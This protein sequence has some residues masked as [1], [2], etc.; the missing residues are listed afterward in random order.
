MRSQITDRI[1]AGTVVAL[2][3]L[4][5]L[6]FI[7]YDGPA[8]AQQQDSASTAEIPGLSRQPSAAAREV[9]FDANDTA[10]LLL[11]H[12]TGLFQ[13][14]KDVPLRDLRVNT[15]VLA[16]IAELAKAPIIYT[17]SEP[18][19]SNGPIMSEL[20]AAA[21]NAQYV[22]RKGE[23]SA[24]DNADVV[25]AVEATG[26]K[27]LVMAGVWTS[28]CVAFPALQA[29]ADG[30]K[31]YAVMDASGDMSEMASQTTLARMTQAGIIPVTT[32][33]VLCEFQRTWNRPDAAQWGELYGELV[34][35]YRAVAESYNKAQEVAKKSQK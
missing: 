33:V 17:A 22:A 4:I 8:R 19:G 28:V 13:T 15:V 21:P 26:K 31:V 24:W 11:D 35:H 5:G 23:V 18:N 2:A 3:I 29:K 34:P 1:I 32:N 20:A 30:Y 10:V 27:T 14:V 7:T 6:I 25:K 16:K 12:Q 9:L